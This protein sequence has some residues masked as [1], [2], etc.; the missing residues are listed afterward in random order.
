M[1]RIMRLLVMYD[2]N[3]TDESSRK[4][5]TKFRNGLIRRGYIMLQFSVYYK[6]LNFPS[7]AKQEENY[8]KKVLPSKG[9]IRMILISERQYMNSIFLRGSKRLNESINNASKRVI[10]DYETN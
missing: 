5:Y 3:M 6:I 2:L 8:L 1:D 10:I 9:N 4:E 7:L